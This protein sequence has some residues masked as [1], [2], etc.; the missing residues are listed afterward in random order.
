MGESTTVKETAFGPEDQGVEIL[1]HAVWCRIRVVCLLIPSQVGLGDGDAC[2]AVARRP[3]C[4]RRPEGPGN[5]PNM[6]G[7]GH[8]GGV[9][10]RASIS[11]R[12]SG[13]EGVSMAKAARTSR[14]NRPDPG[15]ALLPANHSP[16]SRR[17]PPAWP[18]QRCG[19]ETACSG[20]EIALTPAI[21]GTHNLARSQAHLSDIPALPCPATLTCCSPIHSFIH[22]PVQVASSPTSIMSPGPVHTRASPITRDPARLSRPQTPSAPPAPPPHPAPPP[23]YKSPC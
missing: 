1:E 3:A 6:G 7:A 18:P 20:A 21:T 14:G 17:L 2:E 10:G 15:S 16:P 13:L 5:V 4:H 22:T 19:P 9:D 8:G 12:S 23:P 11:R